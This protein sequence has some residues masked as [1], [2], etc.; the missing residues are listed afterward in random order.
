MDLT[1]IFSMCEDFYNVN[2]DVADDLNLDNKK[3]L[4][5]YCKKI[6]NLFFDILKEDIYNEKDLKSIVASKIRRHEYANSGEDIHRGFYCPS[7]VREIYVKNVKRGKILKQTT[8]LG[9][10]K[11]KFEYDFDYRDRLIK[12]RH[13]EMIKKVCKNCKFYTNCKYCRI[14]KIA[15]ELK[16]GNKSHLIKETNKCIECMKNKYCRIYRDG[17]TEYVFYD[18]NISF[19]VSFVYPENLNSLCICKYEENLKIMQYILF[20]GVFEKYEIPEIYQ[21]EFENYNYLTDDEFRMDLYMN[22]SNIPGKIF[23]NRYEFTVKNNKYILKNMK[24][25]F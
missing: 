13:N 21:M 2:G 17:E 3:V 23:S 7:L 16:Q 24:T 11:Y 20:V 18:K 4:N 5:L 12:I 1:K 8:S 25:M 19:G 6:N 14:C 15:M 9:S 22:Y 10:N